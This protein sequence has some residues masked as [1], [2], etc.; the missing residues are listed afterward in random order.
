MRPEVKTVYK[1]FLGLDNFVK[2]TEG[3]GRSWA[4]SMAQ[5]DDEWNE[6]VW[7][8]DHGFPVVRDMVTLCA[9]LLNETRT[10]NAR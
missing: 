1:N 5:P 4:Y 8:N 3:S 10:S 2:G 9:E 6:Y 7:S